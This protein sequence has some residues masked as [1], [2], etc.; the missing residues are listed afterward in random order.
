MKTAEH[1]NVESEQSEGVSKPPA[2]CP[3]L[4]KS[5]EGAE[6]N[7]N[8]DGAPAVI[9]NVDAM[10]YVMEFLPPRSLYNIALTCK[11]LRDKVTTKM[12]VQSALSKAAAQERSWRTST[13]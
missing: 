9:M 13:S 1:T 10:V 3:R 11:S 7:E 6:L 2:K 4:L 12:V 8:K 5:E